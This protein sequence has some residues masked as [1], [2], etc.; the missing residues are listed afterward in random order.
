MDKGHPGLNVPDLVS[1]TLGV[2]IVSSKLKDLLEKESGARAEYVPLRI[3]NHKRRVAAKGCFIA[4]VLEA[5]D[6]VD[7]IARSPN[8]QSFGPV[9]LVR[10]TSCTWTR[11][12]STPI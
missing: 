12:A 3:L 5:Q 4:N 1:N 11:R 10:S 9:I 2:E 6:C 7:W 8:L